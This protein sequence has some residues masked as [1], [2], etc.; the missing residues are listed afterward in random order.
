MNRFKVLNT[1]S[2][3]LKYFLICSFIFVIICS[4]FQTLKIIQLEA[5]TYPIIFYFLFISFSITVFSVL[6]LGQDISFFLKIKFIILI[7]FNIFNP[8]LFYEIFLTIF[9]LLVN[10]YWHKP[11]RYYIS[12]YFNIKIILTIILNLFFCFS[13]LYYFRQ[14][15]IL[16]V[17]F[18]VPNI[19]YLY[20]P[21][22]C[23]KI[24]INTPIKFNLA[25]FYILENS[26]KNVSLTTWAV[27][28]LILLYL[29]NS[30]QF[31]TFFIFCTI[32][33]IIA[34]IYQYINLYL[35]VRYI[36]KDFLLSIILEIIVKISLM[37]FLYKIY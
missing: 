15:L 26:S 6:Y 19:L 31:F 33:C 2:L 30:T 24:I 23:K 25:T 12:N 37:L 21:L 9:L 13:F 28:F 17:L 32:F 16:V 35:T 11:I 14:H 34:D 27:P 8:N 29:Y 18:A 7:I 4:H 36:E 22:Y 10:F 1:M 3:L 20:L 5:T